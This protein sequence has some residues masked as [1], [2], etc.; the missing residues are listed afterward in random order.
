MEGGGDG[1]TPFKGFSFSF[2][3]A[4]DVRFSVNLSQK[5]QKLSFSSRFFRPKL[6]RRSINLLGDAIPN[7]TRV[8]ENVAICEE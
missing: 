1:S 5:D 8:W 7:A 3:F 4:F 6:I 2:V